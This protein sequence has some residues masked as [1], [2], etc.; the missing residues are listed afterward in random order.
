MV[1]MIL[2]LV[3]SLIRLINTLPIERAYEQTVLPPSPRHPPPHPPP[4]PPPPPR[5]PHPPQRPPPPPPHP[6]PP[7]TPLPQPS[8]HCHYHRSLLL[9]TSLA[10]VRYSAAVRARG[11]PIWAAATRATY[12]AGGG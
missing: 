10:I 1:F 7:P 4:T 5:P 2:L 11:A 6:P 9:V 3:T 8:P 12:A